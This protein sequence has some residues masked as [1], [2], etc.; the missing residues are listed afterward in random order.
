[1]NVPHVHAHL[2]KDETKKKFIPQNQLFWGIK[3]LGRKDEPKPL[4]LSHIDET[5]LRYFDHLLI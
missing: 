3:I 4:G 1:M 2:N 5:K